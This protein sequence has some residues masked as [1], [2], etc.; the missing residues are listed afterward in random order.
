MAGSLSKAAGNQ[1]QARDIQRTDEYHPAC[2]QKHPLDQHTF[3]PLFLHQIQPR[4]RKEKKKKQQTKSGSSHCTA[5]GK[6]DVEPPN[7]LDS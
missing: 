7:S 5:A 1:S 2:C 4:K 6:E 3:A